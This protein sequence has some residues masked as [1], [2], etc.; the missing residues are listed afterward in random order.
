MYDDNVLNDVDNIV[1]L[2][3]PVDLIE[4]ELVFDDYVGDD[5]NGAT[6]SGSY[7]LAGGQSYCCSPGVVDVAQDYGGGCGCSRLVEDSFDAGY[8]GHDDTIDVADGGDGD[9]G[10]G[11]G[12]E[13]DDGMAHLIAL[14]QP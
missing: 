6:R 12:G 2:V 7:S 3:T 11:G 10:G 1:L 8:D 13:D 4:L 14:P 5:D 9:D